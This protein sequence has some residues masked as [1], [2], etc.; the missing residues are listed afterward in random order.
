MSVDTS[1]CE[2]VIERV[3]LGEPLRELADHVARCGR[4][5]R[6]IAMPKQLATVSARP[7]PGLGFSARMTIGAQHRFAVRRKRRIAATAASAVAAAAVTVFFVT[8]NPAPQDEPRPVAVEAPKQEPINHNETPAA[9]G[10]A[11]LEDLVRL[12]DTKRARRESA[13]WGR[14]KKPLAPYIK[15]VKG[16]AP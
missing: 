2:S 5:Q 14:I 12:A 15:L 4:C 13:P 11:D 9:V 8:R 1:H 3:A 10:D 7:D 16:V 6:L